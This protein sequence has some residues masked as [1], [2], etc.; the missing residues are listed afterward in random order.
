M[1]TKLTLSLEEPIIAK[2]K[3]YA[4]NT[5]RSLSEL[6]ENYFKTLT[7]DSENQKISN[8]LSEIVGKVKLPTD[9]DEKKELLKYYE[10]KHL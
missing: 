5:G 4:K 3:I 8:S 1:N 10:E 7:V 6:V 2:A 9:F